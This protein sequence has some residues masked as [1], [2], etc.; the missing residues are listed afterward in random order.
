MIV[1]DKGLTAGIHYRLLDRANVGRLTRIVHEE[2][3]RRGAALKETPGKMVVE[4]RPNVDWDK[5]RGVLEFLTRLGPGPDRTLIYIG[6]DMTD[7]DAFRALRRK[8]VTVRVGAPAVSK[9]E[10]RLPGV[11][12][13]WALLRALAALR[14]A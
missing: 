11:S 5:G 8:A 2:I 3:E 7:E 12:R 14:S 6:D 9:A 13:V 1:E 4:I 10:F